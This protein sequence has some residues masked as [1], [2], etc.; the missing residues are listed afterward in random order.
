M[1][2][3]MVVLVFAQLFQ[4]LSTRMF[5]YFGGSIF[6]TSTWETDEGCYFYEFIHSGL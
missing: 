1:N 4:L 3:Q 2:V 5:L 6:N